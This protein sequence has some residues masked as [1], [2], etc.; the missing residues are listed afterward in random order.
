MDIL[1]GNLLQSIDLVNAENT[2]QLPRP[3]MRA[4]P[5][6]RQGRSHHTPTNAM[7]VAIGP[8]LLG[9]EVPRT[10]MMMM[11]MMMIMMMMMMMMMMIATRIPPCLLACWP[12]LDFRYIYTYSPN[13][14]EKIQKASYI[15]VS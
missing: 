15:P 9:L 2:L 1:L 14:P 3:R 5:P 11:M 10:M 13:F 7:H 12:S 8:H 4:A 6:L